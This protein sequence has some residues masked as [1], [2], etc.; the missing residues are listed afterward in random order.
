MR[1][2][3]LPDLGPFVFRTLSCSNAVS[4]PPPLALV[5]VHEGMDGQLSCTF[6][7]CFDY[8]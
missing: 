1:Y 6:G 3:T 5:D 8:S 7:N 4:T 2:C